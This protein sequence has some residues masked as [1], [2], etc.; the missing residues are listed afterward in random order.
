MKAQLK[1]FLTA[2]GGGLVAMVLALG[3]N[4]IADSNPST[5]Q[6]PKLIPYHGTLEKDGHGLNGAVKLHFRV[7]DGKAATKPVWDEIL[8]VTAYNG[9]FTALLGS[10][11]TA[12]AQDLTKVITDADDLYLGVSIVKADSTEIALS[13]RQRFLPVPYAM[14]TTA[15]TD[16]K[17]GHDLTVGNDLSVNGTTVLKGSENDGTKAALMIDTGSSNKMLLDGNEI[18]S[19]RSSLFL[20]N[21][22]HNDVKIGGNLYVNGTDLRFGN[23]PNRGDGGRAMVHDDNDTLVLNY[24]GDFSGGTRIDGK[25]VTSTK[26]VYMKKISM[27]K[28]IYH[29]TGVDDKVWNCA[30]GGIYFGGGDIDEHGNTHRIMQAYTYKKSGHWWIAADFKSEDDHESHT[31]GIVCFRTGISYTDGWW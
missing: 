19:T 25:I 31:M 16:F 4:A 24:N 6:T 15:S 7:F 12:H 26:L 3:V 22:S 1:T 21:N 23:D 28:D 17:V 9:K 11:D 2:L 14:W 13:N 29:D 5:D 10:S 8:D 27:G 18:D 20:N 30:I